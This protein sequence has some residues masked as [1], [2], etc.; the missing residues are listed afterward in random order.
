M[1]YNIEWTETAENQLFENAIYIAL[2][3]GETEKAISFVDKVKE[4][5]E[6]LDEMP[7]RGINPR[8]RAIRKKGFRGLI[9]GN[10]VAFYK[11]YE[12]EHLVV[13]EVFASLKE[14]YIHLLI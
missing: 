7:Y 4:A 1:K 9:I 2:S 6:K 14:D 8:D 13:I 12:K 10:H 3:T 11:V 5:T